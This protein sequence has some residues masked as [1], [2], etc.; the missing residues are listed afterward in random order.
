LEEH[1][2]LA[3]WRACQQNAQRHKRPE[4]AKVRQKRQD[5]KNNNNNITGT[6][7]SKLLSSFESE[8]ELFSNF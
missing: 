2:A 1:H 5:K 4:Q 7:S 6:T 3:D 8:E